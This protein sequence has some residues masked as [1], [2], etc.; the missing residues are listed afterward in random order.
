LGQT[1]KKG[2]NGEGK[3][4]FSALKER[5]SDFIKGGD[6]KFRPTDCPVGKKRLELVQKGKRDRKAEKKGNRGQR[7]K[8]PPMLERILLKS[9]TGLGGERETTASEGKGTKGR[10]G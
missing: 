9:K 10:H 7:A 1:G 4:G 3:Q 5:K 2:P 6:S 8:I